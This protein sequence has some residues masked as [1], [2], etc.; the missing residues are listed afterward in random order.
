[1]TAKRED[2]DNQIEEI[3]RMY[4]KENIPISEIAKK[5]GC[6][7]NTIFRRMKIKRSSVERKDAYGWDNKLELELKRWDGEYARDKKLKSIYLISKR[8]KELILEFVEYA[9]AER[10]SKARILHY[11]QE[12][13]KLKK[14]LTKDI[15]KATKKD[16]MDVMAKIE[17]SDLAEWSKQG[18]RITLKKFYRWLYNEKFNAKLKDKEY[19]ELVS[20]IKTTMKN[21][22]HKLPEE[23]LNEDDVKFL[24]E[25]CE[26][27]RD[28]ALIALLWDS[29]CRI[30]EILNLKLK[31]IS[32]DKYGAQIIVDGKTGSRRV[33]LIP[34]VPYLAN[35]KENH[36]LKNNPEA[37]VFIGLGTRNN[38]TRLSYM[39]IDSLLRRLKDKIKINKRINP[40]AFRHGRATYFA[41]RVKEAVMKES[42][43]WTQKSNMVA[44]YVH[45][46]GRDVDK[47]IRKAQG[48]V[49][50]EERTEESKL[51]PIICPRCKKQN[52]ATAKYCNVCS[53]VLD[54]EVAVTRDKLEKQI[55][56]QPL[57][58]E[59]ISDVREAI[60]HSIKDTLLKDPAFLEQLQKVKK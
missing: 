51:K 56:A 33:R 53:M 55:M 59:G 15:D 40:H 35:L 22:K 11:L 36:P 28:K 16:I 27:V 29:G 50:E 31:H 17:S 7:V 12:L 2:V 5:I 21:G 3:K 32:F 57:K 42:F 26:T 30:G 8:D 46:A 47:E 25:N 52:E 23:I 9:K 6:G 37:F 58:A 38:K 18:Y 54:L 10:L 1:M 45:L 49:D 24:I 13:R 41:S 43:G 39:A 14:Y 34:S 4:Y 20:W 44:T 60:F 48:I 19:P